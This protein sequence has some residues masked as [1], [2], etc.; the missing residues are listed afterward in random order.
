MAA[1]VFEIG[2]KEIVILGVMGVAVIGIPVA[3]LVYFFARKPDDD[4]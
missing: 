1:V 4:R 2:L 3:L